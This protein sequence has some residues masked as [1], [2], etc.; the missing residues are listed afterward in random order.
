MD[1]SSV[2]VKPNRQSCA[3]QSAGLAFLR[4]SLAHLPRHFIYFPIDPTQAAKR[5][6]MRK[7]GRSRFDNESEDML[8]KRFRSEAF[9]MTQIQEFVK[10]EGGNIVCLD[11]L[12]PIG[13][14]SLKVLDYISSF[15][16]RS[17][18]TNLEK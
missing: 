11:P 7:H 10:A 6:T 14:N 13:L 17:I 8:L 18:S 16:P 15:S 3:C 1:L 9:K 2:L 12:Q 5:V 4:Y